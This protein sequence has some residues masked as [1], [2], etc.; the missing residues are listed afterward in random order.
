MTNTLLIITLILQSEG[1]KIVPD[2]E[3]EDE[4]VNDD[5]IELSM[6]SER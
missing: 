2:D 6:V 4:L 5:I 1:W 3:Y